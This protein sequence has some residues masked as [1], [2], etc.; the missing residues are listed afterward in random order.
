MYKEL[1]HCCFGKKQQSKMVICPR[2]I[3]MCHTM[4]CCWRL[5][6]LVLFEMRSSMALTLRGDGGMGL[7]KD[8][9]SK[10]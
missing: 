9:R 4:I 7:R 1:E 2:T 5:S 10:A 3:Q 6:K 8:G